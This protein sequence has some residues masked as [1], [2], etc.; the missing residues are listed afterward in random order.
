MS[1]LIVMAAGTEA[2]SILVTF[3]PKEQ[4]GLP[5]ED[6]TGCRQKRLAIRSRGQHACSIANERTSTSKINAPL[7]GI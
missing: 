3:K 4:S 1:L 5:S 7:I 2:A 6:W